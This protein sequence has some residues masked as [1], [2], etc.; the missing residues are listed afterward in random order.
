[1]FHTIGGRR[2]HSVSFGR[3]DHATLVGVAGAMANWEVWE[4]VFELLS[5]ECRVVSFDHD[6][7]GQTKVPVE[8]ISFERHVE[9][10]FSVLEAQGVKRCVIAGDSANAAVATEA[11]LRRP[12]MFDGLVIVNGHVWGADRPEVRRF[13]EAV[14][15][16]FVATIDFFVQLV[17]PEPDSDH[18]KAWLKDIIVRTGPEATARIIESGFGIDLRDRIGDVSV[19]ALVI[20]GIE[21]LL[22]PTALADAEELASLLPECELRLLDGAGH[23]PLLSRPAEV[24]GAIAEFIRGVTPAG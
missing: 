24:A 13:V 18:L 2:V 21:D 6:G 22:S 4:P 1:M 23:L 17:F 8:E 5:P 15:T 10:L 11:V 19:P 12:E 9:T 7:V 14:R 16:D 3:D 20:H